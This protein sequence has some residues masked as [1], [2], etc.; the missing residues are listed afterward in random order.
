MLVWIPIV[1]SSTFEYEWLWFATLWDLA[2]G[3]EGE[4]GEE[5]EDMQKRLL[6]LVSTWAIKDSFYHVIY[7]FQE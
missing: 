3:E 4:E 6:F 1:R 7:F 5:E 2:D